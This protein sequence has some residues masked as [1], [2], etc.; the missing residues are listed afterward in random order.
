M[1]EIRTS[2]DIDEH[3]RRFFATAAG[4]IAAVQL[5]VAP[6]HAQGT[7]RQLPTIKPGTNTSF[8]PLKQIDAGVPECWLRR[9]RPG[10]WPGRHSSARLALRHPQLR[11]CRAVAGVGRLPG[12]R[13]VSARLWHDALSFERHVPQ[14]PAVG[15]RR[16]RHR[17]DGCAEDREGDRSPASIGARG[18]PTSSR[19]F[20]PSACKAHGLRERLS[21]RQ[22]GSQQD[23]VAAAGRAA[24][25]VPVSTSPPNAAGP[26]T[27]NTGASSRS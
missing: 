20:G 25:V 18:R 22:P 2:G 23:A 24:M 19:R 12:D 10:R 8:G 13:S 15:A 16:R 3:R 17:F 9:S 14:R 26:A 1:G 27:T 11:R 7:P 4:T 21:D 6:A 5:G